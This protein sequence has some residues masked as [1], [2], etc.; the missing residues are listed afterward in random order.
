MDR[1]GVKHV[2]SENSRAKGWTQPRGHEETVIWVKGQVGEGEED[3]YS[4][5]L[6]GE[7]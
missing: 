2:E 5:G 7:S 6:W 3:R 4:G 1:D